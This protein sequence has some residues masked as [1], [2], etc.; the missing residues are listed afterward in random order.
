MAGFPFDYPE[1]EE[2]R[3]VRLDHS[4]SDG[5]TTTLAGEN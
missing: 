4:R 5:C 3:R 1:S 2:T